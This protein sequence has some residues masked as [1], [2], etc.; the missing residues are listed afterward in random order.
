MTISPRCFSPRGRGACRRARGGTLF[1]GGLGVRCRG[2]SAESRPDVGVELNVCGLHSADRRFPCGLSLAPGGRLRQAWGPEAARIRRVRPGARSRGSSSFT[3][4]RAWRGWALGRATSYGGTRPRGKRNRG[5]DSCAAAARS[6]LGEE[7]RASAVVPA[8]GRR[9]YVSTSGPVPRRRAGPAPESPAAMSISTSAGSRRTSP[10]GPGRLR[11][12]DSIA[13]R[14][15]GPCPGGQPDQGQQRDAGHDHRSASRSDAL[16]GLELTLQAAGCPDRVGAIGG[17]AAGVVA[18][19][20]PAAPGKLLSA[21]SQGPRSGRRPPPGGSGRHPGRPVDGYGSQYCSLPRGPF[22][23]TAVVG[24]AR[25]AAISCS[26]WLL[27]ANGESSPFHGRDR[28]LLQE[29]MP[30][31]VGRSRSQPAGS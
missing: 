8:R 18:A 4:R 5:A 29:G 2:A 11:R 24:Q 15:P 31:L 6:A 12:A 23:G 14:Q 25:Q 26:T 1:G 13:A 19:S 3:A 10:P 21:R 27:R 16:S 17:G 28:C 22:G 20:S 9:W 30:S 7:T